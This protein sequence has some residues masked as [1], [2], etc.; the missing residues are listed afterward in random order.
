MVIQLGWWQSFV[1]GRGGTI[2]VCTSASSSG[3]QVHPRAGEG[4]PIRVLLPDIFRTIMQL[5]YSTPG[6]RG[7]PGGGSPS[8]TPDV[9]AT[10]TL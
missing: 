8:P 7:G 1:Y 9:K 10:L 4:S 5:E 3:V 2:M 6:I